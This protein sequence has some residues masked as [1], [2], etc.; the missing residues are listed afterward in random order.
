MYTL[1]NDDIFVDSRP[2]VAIILGLHLED[3]GDEKGSIGLIEEFE[4]LED[5][6]LRVAA[7]RAVHTEEQIAA[8][9]RTE[10]VWGKA[11]YPVKSLDTEPIVT[12]LP[13][14]TAQRS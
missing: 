6:V 8:Y 5:R 4:A 12:S 2:A 9:V 11:K 1:I 14:R 13:I 10:V 7:T 3:R